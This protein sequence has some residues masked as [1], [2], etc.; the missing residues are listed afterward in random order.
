MVF[1]TS[2]GD[3]FRAH[4]PFTLC[5]PLL[6]PVM[7]CTASRFHSLN[8]SSRL[9]VD[10]TTQVPGACDARNARDTRDARGDVGDIESLFVAD[11][12]GGLTRR[13]LSRRRR[14]IDYR[15]TTLT[16]RSLS[17]PIGPGTPWVIVVA[18]ITDK[19]PRVL[20]SSEPLAKLHFSSVE[21]KSFHV[22]LK[23]V[24]AY[25]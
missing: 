15:M 17:A 9:M 13:S 20:V 24:S 14:K 6:L 7:F 12:V 19:T 25:I 3:P 11:V 16:P 22:I 5:L 23:M 18:V 21:N 1:S 8:Y 4:E 10:A 2:A